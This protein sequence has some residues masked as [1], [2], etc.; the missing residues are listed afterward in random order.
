MAKVGF[1]YRRVLMAALKVK[2]QQYKDSSS[3]TTNVESLQSL[4]SSL[5]VNF[6]ILNAKLDRII[7]LLEKQTANG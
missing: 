5:E 7:A 4:K 6:D 3:S 2:Q 1:N